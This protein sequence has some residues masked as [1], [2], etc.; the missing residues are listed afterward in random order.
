VIYISLPD[1]RHRE[2]VSLFKTTENRHVRNRCQ[3]VLL[4]ARGDSRDDVADA[5]GITKRS[6]QRWLNEWQRAGI[7]GLDRRYAPGK[8]PIIPEAL[9]A[10]LLGWVRGGPQSVKLERANWTFA[11]LTVHLYKTHGIKVNPSTV[12][13]LCKKKG[14]RLYRPT[15]RFLRADPE[16]QRA[17]AQELAA[18]KK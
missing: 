14:V 10:E 4:T 15:Y 11:E 18:L 5:L 3:A 6:L 17:A 16:K 12:E 1:E 8:V 13:R 2:V 9:H 7:D